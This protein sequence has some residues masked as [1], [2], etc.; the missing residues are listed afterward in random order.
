MT[1]QHPPCPILAVPLGVNTQAAFNLASHVTP[2][3]P[4]QNSHFSQTHH[5]SAPVFAQALGKQCPLHLPLAGPCFQGQ[6]SS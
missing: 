3:C 4:N 2:S 6:I 5:P 1:N